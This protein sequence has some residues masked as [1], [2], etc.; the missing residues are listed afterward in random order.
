[1]NT[2]PEEIQQVHP[3]KNPIKIFN[4]AKIQQSHQEKGI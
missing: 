4:Q 3:S 2:Y 1:M